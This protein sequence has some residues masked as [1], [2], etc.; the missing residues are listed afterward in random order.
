MTKISEPFA[1]AKDTEG[2]KSNHLSSYNFRFIKRKK[3]RQFIL[4]SDLTR[5]N[6]ASKT[7]L[8]VE[9]ATFIADIKKVWESDCVKL[10]WGKTFLNVSRY[11]INMFLVSFVGV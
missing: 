11:G 2:H 10:D 7:G 3:I 1:F 9:E 6:L 5:K 4:N 8:I